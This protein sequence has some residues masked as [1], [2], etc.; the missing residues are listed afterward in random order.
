M[1]NIL[2]YQNPSSPLLDPEKIIRN[3]PAREWGPRKMNEDYTITEGKGTNFWKAPFQYW[4]NKGFGL[5]NE[6]LARDLIEEFDQMRSENPDYDYTMD[7]NYPAYDDAINYINHLEGLKKYLGLPYD[8][9]LLMESQYKPTRLQGTNEKTYKFRTTLTPGYWDDVVE[10]MVMGEHNKN[11]YYDQSLNEFT[12]YRDRDEKGDFVSIYDEWDYN[13]A[14]RGGNK[15]LNKVIDSVTGGK[16]FVIYDRVYLDDY[17]DIPEEARGNPFIT[18][19]VVTAYKKGGRIHIKKKNRGKFT[20]AAKRAG[21]GVQ[22]FARHVLANKDK[23]SST[24]VKRANFAR[25]SKKFKHE[26]GGILK[27]LDYANYITKKPAY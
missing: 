18:P 22:E 9:G 4:G 6:K 12:A 21:M 2:K 8:T 25:N 5:Q 13:P 20:A 14:V 11:Q 1:S 15:K 17:Y 27:A 24:L 7:K 23:Y 16:P 10:D 26:N 3:V 19:A